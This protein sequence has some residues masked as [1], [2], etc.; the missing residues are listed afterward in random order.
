MNEK[1]EGAPDPVVGTHGRLSPEELLALI[2]AER[3][4]ER[5]IFLENAYNRVCGEWPGIYLNPY[6]LRMTV[7]SYFCDLYRLKFFRPV[8]YANEHKKAAY[9]MK[10]IARVRP[11]QMTGGYGA[12]TPTLMA[13]AYF[14]LMAGLMFLHIDC[15][16]RNNQWWRKYVTDMV[17]FLHYHSVSVESLSSEMRVLQ[18][19][20][21]TRHE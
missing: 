17:Y 18:E 11:I 15:D 21:N 10:W 7:E 8:E 20:Q 6:L 1:D 5:G 2:G 9:T 4:R 12:D 13:N 16:V 14:A 19:L 3:L